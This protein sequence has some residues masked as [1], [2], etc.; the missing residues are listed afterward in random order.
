M[1]H[2]FALVGSAH[3]DA[4]G[5]AVVFAD[6]FLD[7]VRQVGEGREP[8]N[9]EWLLFDMRVECDLL[10]NRAAG[11]RI[12]AAELRRRISVGAARLRAQGNPRISE[13]SS[14]LTHLN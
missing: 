8:A 14:C 4:D 5:Y 12:S 13:I 3:D 6:G 11:D 1:F 7:V 9:A 2:E 10:D